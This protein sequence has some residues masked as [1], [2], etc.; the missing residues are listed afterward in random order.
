MSDLVP[1]PRAAIPV[2]PIGTAVVPAIIAAAGDQAS[3][4]YVD[5]F[6]ANIRN[7]NTRRAYA[8]ACGTFLAWADEG[9]RSL[10]T[11]RPYDVS[12]YIESRQQTH[13]APDV[14][15][16]LAAIRMLF[17]WL[18]TGQILPKTPPPCEARSTS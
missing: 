15:Q 17:D 7:V 14:K 12:L 13:S 10:G 9:S 18:I 5:S 8:R 1:P 16:A 11:I 4:R 2:S 3:W 6:T